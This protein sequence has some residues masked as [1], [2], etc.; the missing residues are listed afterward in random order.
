MQFGWQC[1]PASPCLPKSPCGRRA[2]GSGPS[3]TM[4]DRT[5]PAGARGEA[6]C[7]PPCLVPADPPSRPSPWRVLCAQHG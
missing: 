6:P 1:S 7:I 4:S 3:R 2:A 5:V